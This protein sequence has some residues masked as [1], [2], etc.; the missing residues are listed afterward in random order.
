MKRW[1][2]NQAMWYILGISCYS[3]IVQVHRSLGT[4]FSKMAW[5]TDFVP[6][7]ETRATRLVRL[8]VAY[9][10]CTAVVCEKEPSVI[11]YT[12]AQISVPASTPGEEKSIISRKS[13]TLRDRTQYN[14]TGP[15]THDGC[16]Y[17][18]T[19]QNKWRELKWRSYLLYCLC[20]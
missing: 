7:T 16:P 17:I 12:C 15:S 1:L 5:T 9:T 11:Q 18:V 13:Q 3:T 8:T 10:S 2:G 4:R 20:H 6:T 19:T 14:N